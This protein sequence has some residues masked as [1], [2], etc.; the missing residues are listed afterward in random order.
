M[1]KVIF[2][3]FYHCILYPSEL[4]SN[5][6]SFSFV[7]NILIGILLVVSYFVPNLT[8][9]LHTWVTY[10]C[11]SHSSQISPSMIFFFTSQPSQEFPVQPTFCYPCSTY[12]FQNGPLLCAYEG[13]Q[14]DQTC[15]L[16]AFILQRAF[17]ETSTT[18]SLENLQLS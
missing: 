2:C 18:S 8:S 3:I 10:L 12:S 17:H 4:W 6:F 14:E 16:C 7:A 5:V 9:P 11:S 13:I 15:F 1:K